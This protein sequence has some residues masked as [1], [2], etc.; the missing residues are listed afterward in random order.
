MNTCSYI[1]TKII[2]NVKYF[3]NSLPYSGII[4]TSQNVY[5]TRILIIE[6]ANI[7]DIT[8]ITACFNSA[9]GS[10]GAVFFSRKS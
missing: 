4:K 6:I 9:A 8:M 3:T 7:T 10:S 1:V 2:R 5:F